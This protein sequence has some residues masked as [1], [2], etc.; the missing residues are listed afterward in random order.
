[1]PTKRILT[2]VDL[3]EA[4]TNIIKLVQKGNFSSE[5]SLLED[6]ENFA[7]TYML[8]E[9]RRSPLRKLCP[10]KVKGVL[11]VGGRLRHSN[12]TLKRKYPVLLPPGDH[13]T[14]LIIMHYHEQEGHAGLL[15]TLCALQEFYWIVKGHATVRRVVGKCL[16]CKIKNPRP[17]SQ[18]MAHLP[19]PRVSPGKPAFTCV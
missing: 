17:S 19:K 7:T 4:T 10:V 3:E 2:T 18:T 12:L 13:V 14:E 8:K 6:N 9:L 1:M 15:H 16:K 11:C 5:L